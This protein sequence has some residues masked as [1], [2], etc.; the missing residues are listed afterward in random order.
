[1]ATQCALTTVVNAHTCGITIPMLCYHSCDIALV[2]WIV[3]CNCLWYH[4]LHHICCHITIK[5]HIDYVF[6]FIH[7]RWYCIF[8]CIVDHI[9][10][11]IL[12]S[13]YEIW[14]QQWYQ[15]CHFCFCIQKVVSYFTSY[16]GWYHHINIF[17]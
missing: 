3:N 9:T 5:I 2:S 12:F 15:I 4:S 1:M 11:L 10:T 8:P 14:Y 7:M 16:C 6:V 17:L 13:S